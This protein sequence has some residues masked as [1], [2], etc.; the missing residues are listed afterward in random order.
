MLSSIVTG[1]AILII[2]GSNLSQFPSRPVKEKIQYYSP[3][4]AQQQQEMLLNSQQTQI[5]ILRQQQ[6][7]QGIKPFDW[8]EWRMKMG[9]KE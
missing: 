1:I 5:D 8:K 7:L 9:S 2:G 3:T 6:T 4:L